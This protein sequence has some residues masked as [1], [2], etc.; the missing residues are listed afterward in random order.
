M[1]H[2]CPKQ[3]RLHQQVFLPPS[4]VNCYG[5]VQCRWVR[6]K[7][8]EANAD[9]SEVLQWFGSSNSTPIPD[10]VISDK[11]SKLQVWIFSLPWWQNSKRSGRRRFFSCRWG[12][13]STQAW[14]PTYVS[15]LRNPQMIW[16]WRATVE[17]YIDGKTEE[18]GKKPVPVP[19]CPPQITHG[20]TRARTRASAVRGRRL[21]TWAMARREKTLTSFNINN[22]NGDYITLESKLTFKAQWNT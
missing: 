9:R 16:V 13:S 5:W 2:D 22:V 14:M 18:L 1:I 6:H 10:T 3:T 19:L 12:G 8:T 21:T 4:T 15:I 17:W 11:T 20:L 7:L